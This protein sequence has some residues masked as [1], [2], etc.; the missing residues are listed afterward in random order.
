ML[1]EP[2]SVTPGGG[3][4][5]ALAALGIGPLGLA[6]LAWDYGTKHGDLP[7]LGTIA[8]AAPVLSTLLLVLL[9]LAQPTVQLMVACALV[10]GGA[11]IATRRGEQQALEEIRAEA[12]S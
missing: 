11:W 5:L 4:W 12:E 9:G 1:V 2:A 7:V 3:E 6:F 10:V 8:Y